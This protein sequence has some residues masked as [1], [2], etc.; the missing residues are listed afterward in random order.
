MPQGPPHRC[1]TCRVLCPPGTPRYCPRCTPPPWQGAGGGSTRAGRK[2]RAQVLAEEPTCRD[3]GAPS[4][5]AGHIIAKAKGGPYTRDN[6]KGQC[7]RCNLAQ[8]Y[9]D[10]KR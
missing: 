7:T 1:P 9:E 5:D 4:T 8:L 6:L 3:C 10:K 2:L